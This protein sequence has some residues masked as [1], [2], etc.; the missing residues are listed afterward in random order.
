LNFHY[1]QSDSFQPQGYAVGLYL[2]PLPDPTGHG[3]DYGF[4]LNLFNGKLVLR[5][6]KY[7]TT[8][9]DSRNGS[10][11]II[12]QRIR[13][14]DFDSPNGNQFFNLTTRARA[15]VTNA[16]AAQGRTLSE[17][18]INQEISRITKLD[19]AFFTRPE[20]RDEQNELV[21]ET[22]DVTAKGVEIEVHW[23]PNQF[24]TTK[25]NVTKQ[26]SIDSK[27]SPA[28][29]RWIQERLPVW[30]SIIDPE[31][32]RPWWTERYNGTNSPSQFFASSVK[33][34]YDVAVANQGK[35][36]PQIREYRF[37]LSTSYRLAGLGID[38]EWMKRFTVG[39]ALRWED[40]AAIGYYGLEQLPAIITELDPNRPIY[41]KARVYVDLFTS[42]RMKLSSKVG[43][44]LQLNVRNV[45]ENGRLQAISAYPDGTPNAYRIVDPRQFIL[46]AT[47]DL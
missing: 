1:N 22:Q 20:T 9:I 36:R 11:R 18:Q 15:W 31:I 27:M 29:T 39:G 38:R 17:D 10:M 32:N 35:S 14:L 4:S 5:A 16:A 33:T 12:A 19:V 47:F 45:Q 46:S 34:P 21:S 8:Q 13:N 42:Y 24:W 37:N 3:K 28:V 43:A 7:E 25:F 44:T 30:Q 26:Q 23:N 2:G 40:K 6:N 41:D